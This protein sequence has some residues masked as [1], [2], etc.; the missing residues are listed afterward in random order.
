MDFLDRKDEC[1]TFC[2]ICI[3]CYVCWHIIANGV[4]CQRIIVDLGTWV[5][6]FPRR[7]K[8]LP[9]D[10]QVRLRDAGTG[11]VTDSFQTRGMWV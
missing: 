3:T 1:C 6:S 8:P 7:L 11:P 2:S 4:D 9:T 10:R 5:E